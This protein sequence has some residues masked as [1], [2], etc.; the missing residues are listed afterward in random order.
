MNVSAA[1]S[2][3]CLEAHHGSSKVNT[4]QFSSFWSSSPH[5]PFQHALTPICPYLISVF[6]FFTHGKKQ[7]FEAEKNS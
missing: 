3:L 4:L 7:T 1:V 2:A 6:I 5:L